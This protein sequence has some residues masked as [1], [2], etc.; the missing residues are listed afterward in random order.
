MHD[1]RSLWQKMRAAG[2]GPDQVLSHFNVLDPPVPVFE[3]LDHMGT[4]VYY[5]QHARRP[6]GAVEVTESLAAVYLNPNWTFGF[7]RFVMATAM[8]HM[9]RSPTRV[10]W[11]CGE[12]VGPRAAYHNLANQF[13]GQLLMPSWMFL[14]WARR[15]GTEQ[16]AATFGAP[17]ESVLQR[18]LELYK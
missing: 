13:A 1:R 5:E 7:S 14:V 17:L 11:Q 8:G 2:F 16:L 3:M 15:E 4:H 9:M 10:L 6:Y 12:T 18:T